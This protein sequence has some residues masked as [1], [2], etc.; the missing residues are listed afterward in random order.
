M[1]LACI[2]GQR[3]AGVVAYPTGF[4]S[5]TVFSPIAHGRRHCA[6]TVS[7]GEPR[8]LLAQLWLI[9]D[10]HQVCDATLGLAMAPIATG[11]PPPAWIASAPSS[12]ALP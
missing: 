10:D 7:T 6:V 12:E 3:Y 2:W 8:H 5:R 1:H 9:D 4:S 11:A